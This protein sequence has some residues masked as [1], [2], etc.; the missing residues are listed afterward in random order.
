MHFLWLVF[1]LN[2]IYRDRQ[3]D[4]TDIK[5]GYNIKYI[6]EIKKGVV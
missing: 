4:I 1:K 5:I 3:Y 6:V 2:I